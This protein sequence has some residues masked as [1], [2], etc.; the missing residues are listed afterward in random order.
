[1]FKEEEEDAE[2][3]EEEEGA[4]VSVLSGTGELDPGKINDITGER[5]GRGGDRGRG[6]NRG[7]ERAGSIR[8]EVPE[9]DSESI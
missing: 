8:V 5:R 7:M 4:P 6:G 1:M 9:E 2:E 3:E